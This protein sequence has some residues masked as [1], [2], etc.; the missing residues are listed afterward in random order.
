[1]FS[2]R[3]FNLLAVMLLLLAASGASCPGM[4]QQYTQ[5]LARALPPAPTLEQVMNVVNSNSGQVYSLYTSQ[6]SVVVPGAPTSLRTT[7]AYQRDR[8]FRL[9]SNTT[10]S[11][12]EMDLG[13]NDELFWFWIKRSQPPAFYFCR[14][15]QFSQSAARQI[16]PVE[17]TWIP[18]ALGVV[19]FEPMRH[20]QGPTPISASRLEVRTLPDAPGGNTIV[21]VID[22]SRG[23]VLE[24]HVYDP[25]GNRLATAVLS[26][27]QRDGTTGIT[28]PRHVELDLP[29]RQMQIGLELKDLQINR[30]QPSQADLWTKPSYPGYTEVDL[31]DPNLRLVQPTARGAMP[32]A[33]PQEVRY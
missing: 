2:V 24:E 14:H 21:T 30:L 9:R 15:E 6:A 32:H 25:A 19:S 27:H 1:M 28:L 4:L 3:R 7:V 22:D 17:L 20:Y 10:L 8:R 29:T 33:H 23:I 12:S 16:L 31:A 13:S 18:R 11:G 26:R 5:P